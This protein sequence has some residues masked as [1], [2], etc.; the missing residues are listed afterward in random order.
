MRAQQHSRVTIMQREYCLVPGNVY[1]SSSRVAPGLLLLRGFQV[2]W[3]GRVNFP[4]LCLTAKKNVLHLKP[5]EK[6]SNRP[7]HRFWNST[8]PN[9]TALLSKNEVK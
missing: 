8:G 4:T 3:E 9:V 2:A 7:Q 5:M 6:V 1:S